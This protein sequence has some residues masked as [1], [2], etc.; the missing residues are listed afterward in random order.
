MIVAVLGKKD[1][2]TDAVEDYCR[3]LGEVFKHR[4]FDFSLVR[5]S[6]EESGWTRALGDLWRRSADWREDWALVQYTALMWSRRGFPF[7]FL[8]VLG[9][10][11]IRGVC[12]AVVFH[13]PQPYGGRRIVDRIRRVCQLIVMRWIYSFSS[14]TILTIPLEQASWLPSKPSKANFIPVCSTLPVVGA[15]TSFG[16]NGREGKTITVLAVSEAADISKEVADITNAAKR[17]AEHFPHVRLVTVGRG[18]AQSASRFREALKGSSVE[19]S[20]LGVLPGEEVSQVLANG[21]VSLCVRGTITTQRS[22][23]ICSIAN[24]IPLVAYAD[25]SLPA[26]LAEAGVMGVPYLDGEKL[27]DATVRVLTDPQLWHDLHERSRR[28]H[29]KY[30]SREAVAARFLEVL[31]QA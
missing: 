10:L 30:F 3:L 13:D 29:E 9:V 22:S 6:W 25:L 11:K 7:I 18:S 5:V 12:S 31:H 14:V 17:A 8:L 16:G 15:A 23:A 1:F 19:F 4:G 20:A 21:D 2:P 26:P 28:A 27:A 24:G